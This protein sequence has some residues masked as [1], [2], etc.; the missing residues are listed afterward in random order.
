MPSARG[1][2]GLGGDQTPG[3]EPLDGHGDVAA[4]RVLEVLREAAHAAA[5][6]PP[7]RCRR[8]AAGRGPAGRPSGCRV[9]VADVELRRVQP[10]A[11]PGHRQ[12]HRRPAPDRRA[13]RSAPASRRKR[14]A[15]LEVAVK[16]Q[17]RARDASVSMRRPP[18]AF[19]TPATFTVLGP[20]KKSRNS[21][22][23]QRRQP[24]AEIDVE[25]E[26]RRRL[27][28]SATTPSAMRAL[29]ASRL[30]L[31]STWSSGP[32]PC[33]VRSIAG[34][35]LDPAAASP[36]RRPC[37]S[38]SATSTSSWRV[39]IGERRLQRERAARLV[40]PLDVERR[41]R[42]RRRRAS[43]RPATLS[44]AARPNTG[45]AKRDARERQLVRGSPPPA[46]RAA[47]TA[48]SRRCGSCCG[49]RR[50]LRAAQPD[51]AVG[52][53]AVDVD[54]AAQQRQA[55]PVELGILDLRARGPSRSEMVI[56]WIRARDESAPLTPLSRIC[57]PGRREAVLDEAED[58]AVVAAGS[59]APSCATAAI[60]TSTSRPPELRGSASKRL[61]DADV[62]RY[63][64]SPQGAGCNGVATSA[65]ST[66]MR[67]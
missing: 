29:S 25:A 39:S 23:D 66:P 34:R 37:G 30:K 9:A 24:A 45:S 63:R 59:F 35:A 44:S 48:A 60:A 42:A 17:D 40:E 8:P 62:E 38:C 28:R 57:A 26:A 53:R 46:A 64:A 32:D 43:S 61:P 14:R 31:T 56:R 13:S 15:G 52:A 7:S 58:E 27:A 2:L 41:C 18:A 47:R 51:D 22:R 20:A 12:H 33:S 55:A 5:S 6:R 3:R 21:R 10:G 54:P 19:F 67:V 16:L 49:A 4:R 65:R 11:P 36:P 1:D 50:R